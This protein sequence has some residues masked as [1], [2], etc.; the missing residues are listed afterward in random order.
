MRVVILG[1]HYGT[2]DMEDSM[3]LAA[4]F[5]HGRNGFFRGREE[6]FTIRGVLPCPAELNHLS[7]E[8]CIF[9]MVHADK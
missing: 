5:S 4:H 7:C 1:L 6:T 3:P 9:R 2:D 8:V